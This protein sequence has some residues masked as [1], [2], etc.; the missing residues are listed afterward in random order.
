MNALYDPSLLLTGNEMIRSDHPP[1]TKREEYAFITGKFIR[2][3]D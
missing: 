1:D 3:T 2:S